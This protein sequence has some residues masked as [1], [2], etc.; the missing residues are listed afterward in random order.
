MLETETAEDMASLY[1]SPGPKPPVKATITLRVSDS[2]RAM[3]NDTVTLWQMLAKA[4]GE[5]FERIDFSYVCNRMLE[6]G[7][8]TAFGEVGV[9]LIEVD[10]DTEEAVLRPAQFAQDSEDGKPKAF[11]VT[12]A[13][14]KMVAKVI[15]D[16]IVG[17]PKK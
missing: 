4:R 3:L 15:D 11:V 14:W 1:K 16:K 5:P 2:L 6:V 9:K 13:E 10:E 8:D 7:A 12:A 17:K